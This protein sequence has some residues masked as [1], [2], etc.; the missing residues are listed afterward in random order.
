MNKPRANKVNQFAVRLKMLRERFD[1]DSHTYSQ[2]AFARDLGVGQSTVASWENG[3]REPDFDM[4]LK[5][6]DLFG[7]ATDAILGRCQLP[8][9]NV[10]WDS[11]RLARMLDEQGIENSFAAARCG[12]ASE[13]FSGIIN[14]TAIPDALEIMRLS[15]LLKCSSDYLLGLMWAPVIQIDDTTGAFSDNDLSLLRDFHQLNEEGQNYIIDNVRAFQRL[16]K[17]KKDYSPGSLPAAE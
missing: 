9:D 5:I 12:I 10:F 3:D 7:A 17:Y 14:G 16:D 15:E 2:K 13:R 4:L 1:V 6:A 8:E 11:D